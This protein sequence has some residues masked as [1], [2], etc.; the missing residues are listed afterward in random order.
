MVRAFSSSSASETV[1]PSIT[2]PSRWTAPASNSRAS[3][4]EVL[5]L[6]R[7]PTRATLRMR[8][9]GLCMPTLLSSRMGEGPYSQWTFPGTPP[10][11]HWTPSRRP[12]SRC[13]PRGLPRPL[14]PLGGAGGRSSRGV[15]RGRGLRHHGAAWAGRR[16]AVAGADRRARPLAAVALGLGDA[17]RATGLRGR[18]AAAA[19]P[20]AHG[21]GPASERPPVRAGADRAELRDARAAAARR[22]PRAAARSSAILAMA[23]A[24][25][26]LILSRALHPAQLD[27]R[28]GEAAPPVP[29]LRCRS[30]PAAWARRA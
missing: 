4:R 27:A 7:W 6:P 24:D 22:G 18:G 23:I 5:P 25:A 19:A 9:A 1:V 26:I 29:L 10:S 28:R 13:P 3:C 14:A 15:D 11:W 17:R 30:S 2:D 8:S 16:A 12:W 21:S 20:P